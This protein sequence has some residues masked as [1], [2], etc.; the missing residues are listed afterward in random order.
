[1]QETTLP[2]LTTKTFFMREVNDAE[3]P[4]HQR[5]PEWLWG[6]FERGKFDQIVALVYL[7]KEA[8]PENCG[9]WHELPSFT[10]A[11]KAEVEERMMTYA[12]D[13]L[14]FE[15]FTSSQGDTIEKAD[16]ENSQGKDIVSLVKRNG[17]AHRHTSEEAEIAAWEKQSGYAFPEDYKALLRFSNGGSLERVETQFV[18]FGI[19]ECRALH[20]EHDYYT[21]IPQSVVFGADGGGTIYFFDHRPGSNGQ[22]LAIRH[23]YTMMFENAYDHIEAQAPTLTELIQRIVNK[24]KLY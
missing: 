19:T 23:E 10:Q 18:L 7:Y 2:L 21:Y 22:V 6:V 5:R 15:K 12:F 3:I 8:R 4:S 16:W 24:E 13:E 20:R 17:W 9:F 1:M 14:K 11:H